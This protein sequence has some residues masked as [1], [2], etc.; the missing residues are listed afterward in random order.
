MKDINLVQRAVHNIRRCQISSFLE[1]IIR[2]L[3]K[4][5][6]IYDSEGNPL[7]T[8]SSIYSKKFTIKLINILLWGH[9]NYKNRHDKTKYTKLTSKEIF[10]ILY[11]EK[12]SNGNKEHKKNLQKIEKH[13]KMLSFSYTSMYNKNCKLFDTYKTSD[14]D[15]A[16]YF[17]GKYNNSWNTISYFFPDFGNIS[18][19][20]NEIKQYDHKLYRVILLCL[21]VISTETHNENTNQI[22]TL[23]QIKNLFSLNK[24]DIDTLCKKSGITYKPFFDELTFNEKKLSELNTKQKHNVLRGIYFDDNSIERAYELLESFGADLNYRTLF[25][26][27]MFLY[28][29]RKKVTKEWFTETDIDKEI[30]PR[31]DDEKIVINDS[32]VSLNNR[33]NWNKDIFRYI[34]NLYNTTNQKYFFTENY[35]SIKK[36]SK[37]AVDLQ[38]RYL[39]GCTNIIAKEERQIKEDNMMKNSSFDIMKELET[40]EASKVDTTATQENESE[41]VCI[42][43]QIC[44]ITEF[45]DF[46]IQTRKLYSYFKKEYKNVYI[47]YD[48]SNIL[49]KYLDESNNVNKEHFIK[50]LQKIKK[51]VDIWRTPLFNEDFIKYIDVDDILVGGYIH[52]EHITLNKED[53]SDCIEDNDL[54]FILNDLEEL[55]EN[56]ILNYNHDDYDYNLKQQIGDRKISKRQQDKIDN[57]KKCLNGKK[58]YEYKTQYAESLRKRINLNHIITFILQKKKYET[59]EDIEKFTRDQTSKHRGVGHLFR[60]I[61]SELTGCVLNDCFERYLDYKISDED[62]ELIKEFFYV[63]DIDYFALENNL[64]FIIE[65][66]ERDV[67]LKKNEECPEEDLLRAKLKELKIPVG[68]NGLTV[69]EFRQFVFDLIGRQ[70]TLEDIVS[71]ILLG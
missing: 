36:G 25:L 32:V 29:N 3:D 50:Q 14:G 37:K 28:Y 8:F 23:T 64:P 68:E 43:T 65:I 62:E 2:N 48:L 35:N 38:S 12:F 10:N 40:V 30:I 11:K 13:L 56:D 19:D 34:S 21:L 27:K 9:S 66:K 59:I 4:D 18:L 45:A 67:E 5:N 26:L 58:K 55:F 44:E 46:C 15:I 57:R 1:S 6:R 60:C 52:M 17:V 7:N 39:K 69:V 16:Y 33:T 71:E 41:P 51:S 22:V 42:Y 24:D 53:E 63:K 47:A 54:L 70:K 61:L 31:L 49:I 20:F